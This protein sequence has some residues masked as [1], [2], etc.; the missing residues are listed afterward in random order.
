VV[1]ENGKELMVLGLLPSELS[2]DLSA[3]LM[4]RPAAPSVL[5]VGQRFNYTTS[6]AYARDSNASKASCYYTEL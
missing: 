5:K 4:A 3:E 6:S 2:P 1:L